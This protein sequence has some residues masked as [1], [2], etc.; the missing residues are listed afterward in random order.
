MGLHS[1]PTA[2]SRSP[3]AAAFWHQLQ[4]T[5]RSGLNAA[6]WILLLLLLVWLVL[7]QPAQADR[8][9]QPSSVVIRHATLAPG[10]CSAHEPSRMV[11]L[12]DDWR[13]LGMSVPAVA[14]YRAKLYMD[15]SPVIP[16]GLRI[17]RLP[18]NH[19]V[20]VNGIQMSTRHMEGSAITSMATLPYLIELPVN[21]LLAG[22]NDIEIDVRMNPFRKPGIGELK[23]G[24]L[25]EARLAHDQWYAWTVDLPRIMNLSVAG[26]ALFLLL[27]W[28]TRPNDVIFAYFGGLMVVM[29]GRNAFYFVE[30][31]TWPAPVVDWMFFASQ[32][33]GT[34]YL[35]LFGMTYAG[36]RVDRWR[37]PLRFM[38]FG[39]PVLALLAMGTPQLDQLRL[40]AYPLMMGCGVLIVVRVVQAA[41]KKH[42]IEAVAMTLGPV[43]TMVSVV[44]DYL[45]LTPLL[46]VTDLYW[47]P[48]MA[49]V[50]FLGFALTLMGK[51]VE[52]MNMAERMNVILEERVADRT[53]ALET[54]NQ[55]K[56]RFLAAA[57][58]DLRQPTAAIGLLV[59]LL[60]QQSK[61]PEAREL[62]NMLDEAVASMESLLVGLLDI[63]RLDA[64]AV[65]PEFQAVNLHDVFQAVKVHEH[66]AAQAKGLNLR[67]RLP[68]GAAG[69]YPVLHTDPMLLHSVLR[70]LVSNAIRYTQRGGVL[71]AARRRG[72]NRLRIEVWDTG[73]G[74]PADQR[75]RIFEEFYQVGNAA[76]DRSK[77]IGLGL[78][79]V[80]RMASILGERIEVQSRAGRGSCFAIELPLHDSKPAPQAETEQLAEPLRGRILWL[81][82]D[83]LL[84]R[85][86]LQEMLRNWGAQVRAWGDAE[87]LFDDLP[88]LMMHTPE[89]LPDTVITD[90]RLP[91]MSGVELVQ[92]LSLQLRVRRGPLQALIISGDTDPSELQR[93]G[94]SG[95]T[96]MPKPFRSERL[97][98]QLLHAPPNAA[99]AA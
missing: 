84:L 89:A 61:A 39:L 21:V 10:P 51:F 37:W 82:E 22:E 16:W 88:H 77:G 25:T 79:I 45:F 81:V 72:K 62:V 14:C 50:I 76:R 32:A 49:P 38:G 99:L 13:A 6:A 59:S 64:G 63:S 52:A 98:E 97:L 56:T 15:R 80:R 65:K 73:I 42:I 96:V 92:Q 68:R 70:N 40:L 8:P 41:W 26:M 28:R 44:H 1:N 7:W 86:A 19:R 5:F 69:E 87:A 29:C 55:S 66:S 93:L 30:T 46:P 91:G 58:H 3:E 74:I 33:V 24:P 43:G 18:G 4:L 85:R 95:L 78:A 71:V 60:R 23:V 53:R 9:A 47:T 2:A 54:A 27:A 20:T 11:S 67:F 75:E 36:M 83:D 12:P 90:Y 35:C 94:A 57:S 48:Y 17:E 31:I 34:Y